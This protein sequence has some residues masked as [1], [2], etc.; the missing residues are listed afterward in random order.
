MAEG[1]F[2][3]GDQAPK[4]KNEDVPVA[5]VEER[6]GDMLPAELRM[7][8]EPLDEGLMVNELLKKGRLKNPTLTEKSLL[9]EDKHLS[10]LLEATQNIT[11]RYQLLGT[12]QP[13]EAP[14]EGAPACSP[15]ALSSSDEMLYF[16]EKVRSAPG[17]AALERRGASC[18]RLQLTHTKNSSALAAERLPAPLAARPTLPPAYSP[19]QLNVGRVK[20]Q[21]AEL[22][23][24]TSSRQL[25]AGDG[26]EVSRKLS[27]ITQIVIG[28]N[29]AQP[30]PTVPDWSPP[31]PSTER[32]LAE[33]PASEQPL[34]TECVSIRDMPVL[35]VLD[36]CE[37]APQSSAERVRR[38]LRRYYRADLAA[39]VDSSSSSEV[40]CSDD[41]SL[42]KL[43][44]ST[45]P[46]T[47]AS[48]FA[49][50]PTEPPAAPLTADE[51][52][53]SWYSFD[54]DPSS[55][56]SAAVRDTASSGSTTGSW[57]SRRGSSAG[58][59]DMNDVA[60]ECL[61]ASSLIRYFESIH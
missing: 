57:A 40:T 19:S 33:P 54:S 46:T 11:L 6:G 39:T 12:L 20:S 29:K 45:V 4:E 8:E 25:R 28:A 5:M 55:C 42:V 61:K 53:T 60:K 13:T 10:V 35:D 27:K 23:L 32:P 9:L 22:T 56:R 38:R 59:E 50:E 58:S 52:S 24:K 51:S 41:D 37:L 36:R 49:T 47:E 21:I 15:R 17:T 7:A 34:A 30:P 14:P 1:A 2:V 18:S 44:L 43:D 48:E 31:Q 16:K 26:E 3:E